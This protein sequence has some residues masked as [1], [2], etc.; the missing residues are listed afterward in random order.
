[1][2]G[3]NNGFS[4]IFLLR[5]INF[6]ESRNLSRLGLNFIPYACIP[7]LFHLSSQNPFPAF[8]FFCNPLSSFFFIPRFVRKRE[9]NRKS[10]YFSVDLCKRRRTA[11]RTASILLILC[12]IL[13]KIVDYSRNDEFA[14]WNHN[15][16]FEKNY[17]RFI[18]SIYLIDHSMKAILLN[19]S[20][21]AEAR[22]W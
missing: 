20:T 7:L 19:Q 4:T 13:C 16:S 6:H 15:F 10:Y 1:M 21:R 9:R 18:V 3:L 22:C 8:I 12:K 17:C 11:K 5:S 14:E 2:I